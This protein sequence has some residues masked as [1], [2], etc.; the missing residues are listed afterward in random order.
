MR[1]SVKYLRSLVGLTLIAFGL[2]PA[3]GAV[4]SEPPG[5]AIVGVVSSE[6]SPGANAVGVYDID[7]VL[8]IVTEGARVPFELGDDVRVA[9]LSYEPSDLI[10]SV[11]S[12]ICTRQ[13][14]APS[15]KNL[16]LG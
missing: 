11:S 15:L 7:R 14:I 8:G 9:A 16:R 1:I 6:S 4:V 5:P 2:A 13:P 3:Y 12:V 10:T